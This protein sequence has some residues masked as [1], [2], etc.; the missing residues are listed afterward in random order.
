MHKIV[1][2]LII[3]LA[4]AHQAFAQPP[5]LVIG[6]T[7]APP[8]SLPDQSGMLDR[9]L[10]EA[11]RR[12]GVQV[13]FVTLPSE[14][15]LA[16]AEAGLIDGDNNRVAGL[17]NR[18]PNLIQLPESNM[19]YEFMAFATKP[20]LSING[21]HD[22]DPYRVSYV[23]GWKIL[24]D[25]VK[26]QDVTKVVNPTQLFSFLKAGRTDIVLYDRFGGDYHLKEH[27]V[28]GGYAVEPPL[29]KR[30]MFL[31]LNSKHAEL[32]A[33]LAEALR[34]MKADGTY[35]RYFAPAQ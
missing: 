16:D 24:E 9:M 28:A 33:P 6:T 3:L 23:I 1:A 20:G 15:S 19:T 10:K 25:N 17:Q 31:Y 7:Y 11:F 8:L 14:R 30:E 18:Y 34:S 26:A 2:L 22:L 21:W 5:A 4:V 13:E 12:A 32:V 27:G 35:A 29:A